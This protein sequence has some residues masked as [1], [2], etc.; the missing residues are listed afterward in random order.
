MASSFDTGAAFCL[1]RL[2][3][4]RRDGLRSWHA[5]SENRYFGDRGAGFNN[6]VAGSGSGRLSSGISLERL[7]AGGVRP[8]GSSVF[9]A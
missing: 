6:L 2:C 1:Q 4:R 7:G 3:P 9:P 5:G 8:Q